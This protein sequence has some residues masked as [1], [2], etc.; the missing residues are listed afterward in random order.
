MAARRT[1][2]RLWTDRDAQREEDER[3]VTIAVDDVEPVLR[4]DDP[5]FRAAVDAFGPGAEVDS[6]ALAWDSAV[7]AAMIPLSM[8][9]R[10]FVLAY[11]WRGAETFGHIAR[12]AVATGVRPQTAGKWLRMDSVASAVRAVEMQTFARLGIDA[13]W[14]LREYMRLYEQA[15]EISNVSQ[16]IK[17]C[18]SLLDKIGMHKD[19]GA[20]A[21]EKHEHEHKH[22][23]DV[24][25][26]GRQA[27]LEKRRKE[28]AQGSEYEQ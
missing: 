18:E 21:A 8:K 20:K 1:H 13:E 7:T 24:V 14:V 3:N 5:T 27:V 22:S 11:A 25:V 2:R 23:F 9:Q 19:I 6:D 28:Q 4:A 17:A 26:E 15:Q 12:S 10:A 16:R